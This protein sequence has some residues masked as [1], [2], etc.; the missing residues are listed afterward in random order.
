MSKR[1]FDAAYAVAYMEKDNDDVDLFSSE[2]ESEGEDD[3]EELLNLDEI[4]Q[5]QEEMEV[6]EEDVDLVA[7]TIPETANRNNRITP[8]KKLL[9]RKRQVNSITAALDM[10]NYDPMPPVEKDEKHTGYLGPK[11]KSSTEQIKFTT[12][13]PPPQGL[14]SYTFY[15][16][17]TIYYSFTLL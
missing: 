15:L 16:F 14:V 17:E 10:D 6:V 8:K 2:E 1:T 4:E 9:T 12:T 5:M 11:G 13:P 7:E 3:L